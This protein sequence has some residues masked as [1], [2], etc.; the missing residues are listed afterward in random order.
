M[1]YQVLHEKVFYS[2]FFRTL[3]SITCNICLKTE[4][5]GFF[6]AQLPATEPFISGKY[7][8]SPAEKENPARSRHVCRGEGVHRVYEDTEPLLERLGWKRL[9]DRQKSHMATVVYKSL[10]NFEPEYLEAKFV[11]RSSITNYILRATTTNSLF[12]NP[13]QTI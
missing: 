7:R 2:E 11:N 9:A 8:R 4:N 12:Q 1:T 3:L 5:Y 10:N 6:D 13:A